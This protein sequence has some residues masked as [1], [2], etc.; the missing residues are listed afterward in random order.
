MYFFYFLAKNA[1]RMYFKMFCFYK[2]WVGNKPKSRKTVKILKRYMWK[3]F[4]EVYAKLV[5]HLNVGE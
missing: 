4:W 3:Q 5:I 2:W 1:L